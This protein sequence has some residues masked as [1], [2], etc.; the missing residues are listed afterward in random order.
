ME[1]CAPVPARTQSPRPLATMGA[2][3]LFSALALPVPATQAVGGQ[4]A[5]RIIRWNFVPEN[6]AAICGSIAL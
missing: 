1:L 3:N 4:T 6:R 2:D 5:I